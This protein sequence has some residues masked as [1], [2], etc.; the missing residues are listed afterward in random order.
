MPVEIEAKMRLEDP[1]AFEASL[2]DLGA[3]P[4]ANLLERNT[5]FDT[6]DADLRRADAGLRM[7]VERDEDRGRTVVRFTHKGPRAAGPLK[8]R[9]E[10]E[11]VVADADA[12]QALLE[13]LGYAPVLTFEKRRRRWQFE[14]CLVEIDTLP[15]IGSF[16]E[17]EGP[18]S[19]QVMDARR[20]LGLDGAP[21][22]AR[23][24]LGLLKDHLEQRGDDRKQV[25]FER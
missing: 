10:N 9:Q 15:L 1:A 16:V 11:L 13:A 24:Y 12:A 4:K 6:P 22:I 14:G 2:P 23:S 7:R 25:V 20:R 8:T 3:T 5:Y 18:S 19:Q 17:I 21:L